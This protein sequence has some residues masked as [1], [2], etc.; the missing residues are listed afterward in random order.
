M[1]GWVLN[2]TQHAINL[3]KIIFSLSL[4]KERF[5]EW[6]NS[7]HETGL[8]LYPLQTSEK[9]LLAGGVFRVL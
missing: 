2:A 7:F 5:N 3:G 6:I 1:F 9:T 4:V 8:F